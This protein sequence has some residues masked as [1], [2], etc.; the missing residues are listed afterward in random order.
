MFG[1]NVGVGVDVA[2]T[3]SVFLRAEYEYVQFAPVANLIVDVNS[4]RAGAGFKF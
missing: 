2:L 4:V 3:P 1:F